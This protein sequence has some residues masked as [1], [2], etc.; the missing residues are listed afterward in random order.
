MPPDSLFDDVHRTDGSPSGYSETTFRF[1]NRVRGQLWERERTLLDEWWRAYP[2]EARAEIRGRI[3][4]GGDAGFRSAFC[5]LYVY[6]VLL[7]VSSDVECHPTIP[8][9]QRRPDFRAHTTI[10][11][12][13]VVEAKSGSGSPAELGFSPL[14]STVLDAVNGLRFGRW[15]FRVDAQNEGSQAPPT[16]SLTRGL[17]DFVATLDHDELRTRYEAGGGYFDSAPRYAWVHADWRVEF[18]PIPMPPGRAGPTIGMNAAVAIWNDT[19]P[20]RGHLRDKGRAYGDVGS[21]F[22]LALDVPSLF[23]DD[24]SVA[25]VLYG[26]LQIVL[27]AELRTQT[28]M[29]RA[30][31]GAWYAGNRWRQPQVSG[32]L[33]LR[34]LA[35]HSVTSAVPTLWHHP[36]P[37][38]HV[39]S[40]A[41]IFRQARM[42][43]AE[44]RIDF[45]E[46]IMTP[47]EFFDLPADWPG[48][49][50]PFPHG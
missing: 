5:E 8:N 17:T 16:Q 36:S 11:G 34:N 26:D 28:G 45:T 41:P 48:P 30:A 40:L 46:P 42:N 9:T 1:L 29:R 15:T 3:R 31:N 43:D 18:M 12:P 35:P 44:S 23:D 32:V 37:T 49:E 33:M 7:R 27:D 39:S 24:D 2:P 25:Q 19:G 22:V 20:I 4:N 47:A 14:L 21:A 13:V 50:P 6:Q 10:D 38:W